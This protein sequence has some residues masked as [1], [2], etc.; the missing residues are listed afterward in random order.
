MEAIAGRARHDGGTSTLHLQQAS[1]NSA[2]SLA[3]IPERSFTDQY[4][5][6]VSLRTTHNS[7]TM[8]VLVRFEDLARS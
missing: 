4:P 3:P 2:Q 6:L 8:G 1:V 7:L 5:I